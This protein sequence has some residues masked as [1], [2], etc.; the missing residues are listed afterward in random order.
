MRTTNQNSLRS[1]KFQDLSH[2]VSGWTDWN[3]CLDLKGGPN[4]AKNYV[5][6][7][8]IVNAT[9]DE[10]YKQPMFYI[11][12][13]FSKFIPPGSVRIDLHFYLKPISY[14]GIAFVTPTH[15]RVLVLLNRGNKS[16]TFS[17][18]DRS[19][20]DISLRIQLEPKSIA[21]IIWNK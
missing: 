4:F 2:W 6:A 12:G 15:Q 18:E 8:I 7:P 9:A 3:L 21:T 20:D 14:E 11:L 17:I 1:Q 16:V 19:K 13:H 5:D 10:F